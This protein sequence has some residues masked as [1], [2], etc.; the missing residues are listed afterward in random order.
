MVLDQ[1]ITS[2][3]QAIE[4]LTRLMGKAT[5]ATAQNKLWRAKTLLEGQLAG[6]VADAQ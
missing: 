6:M 2:L 3:E 4:T 5:T 1:S